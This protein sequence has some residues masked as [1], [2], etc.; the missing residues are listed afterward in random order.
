MIPVITKAMSIFMG[1]D[2]K[3]V[4]SFSDGQYQLIDM[5]IKTIKPIGISRGS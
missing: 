2:K 3:E 4:I 1:K 5:G